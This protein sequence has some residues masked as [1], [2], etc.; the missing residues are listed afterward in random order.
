MHIALVKRISATA[1][2]YKVFILYA[3]SDP[4]GFIHSNREN[5]SSPYGVFFHTFHMVSDGFS[6]HLYG[7]D[8]IV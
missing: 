2:H 6:N 5:I 8:D 7:N 1:L 3:F 4:F